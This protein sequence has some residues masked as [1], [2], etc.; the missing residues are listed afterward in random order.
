LAKSPVGSFVSDSI[1]TAYIKDF[2]TF[3]APMV[4]FPG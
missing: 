4:K 3:F 2:A 1:L